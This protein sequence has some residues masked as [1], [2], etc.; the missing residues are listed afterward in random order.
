MKRRFAISV[1]IAL[2]SVLGVATARA[3]VVQK[4][5]LRVHFDAGFA[6]RSLPREHPVPITVR[7]HGAIETTDGSH[8]PPLRWLEVE[9]NRDGHLSTLGLP[10]C[11]PPALQST[12]TEEALDRCRDALI[13]HGSFRANVKL[14]DEILT[15][16]KIL[17]FNSRQ[18]GSPLLLLHFFVR[19]PARFTLVVPMV[20]G[21]RPKGEF[22]TV[23]RAHVPRLGGGFGS[24]TEI[25]LSIGRRYS[26]AGKRRA[27]LSAACGAPPGLRSALFPFARAHFRFEAHRLIQPEPLIKTCRVR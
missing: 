16:G 9:L 11:T 22:G 5:G 21:H 4:E 24:I 8:P 2:L 18:N 13:G 12:S 10:S 27:Y 7:V 17:A 15:D 25:D 3:V 6:P 23:L 26:F 20:I 1:L 19:V 14:G